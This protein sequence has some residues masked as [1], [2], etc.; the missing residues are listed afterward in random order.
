MHGLSTIRKMNN[1]NANDL[2]KDSKPKMAVITPPTRR[3]KINKLVK[4]CLDNKQDIAELTVA[5]LG[6]S[7]LIYLFVLL[8]KNAW[9]VLNSMLQLVNNSNQGK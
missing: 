3:D 2:F 8:A 1:S 6:L 4:I 5:I 7:G 9:L